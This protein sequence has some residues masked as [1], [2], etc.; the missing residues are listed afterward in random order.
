M[1]LIITKRKSSQPNVILIKNSIKKYIKIIRENS[2]NSWIEI[3]IYEVNKDEK[4][5][6][7][8]DFDHHDNIYKT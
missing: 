6:T 8:I 5:V 2:C 7:L 4:I 1:T 3:L